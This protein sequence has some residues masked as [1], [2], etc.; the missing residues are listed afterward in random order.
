MAKTLDSVVT[1]IFKSGTGNGEWGT[2][3][4]EIA[5]S[6]V[7]KKGNGERETGIGNWERRMRSTIFH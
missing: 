4:R 7:F 5:L 3:N 1:A 2:R 6:A